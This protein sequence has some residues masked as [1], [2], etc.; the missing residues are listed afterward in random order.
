M[1][2]KPCIWLSGEIIYG[3]TPAVKEWTGGYAPWS[4]DNT[5]NA[6]AHLT[7]D[8]G[9]ELDDTPI[10]LGTLKEYNITATFS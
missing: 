8:D 2:N 5:K 6:H 9:P 4:G 7:F 1:Y 3:C 10:I